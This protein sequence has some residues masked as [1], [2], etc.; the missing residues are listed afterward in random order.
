[1]VLVACE[2]ESGAFSGERVFRLRLADGTDYSGVTPAQYCLDKDKRGLA[3]DQPQRGLPIGGYV[4]AFLIDNGGEQAT[5][6]LPNGEAVQVRADQVPFRQAQE[7]E[8]HY[9]PL[10]S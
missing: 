3:R 10:G 5:V 7:R 2:I 1:M 4:V 8:A 6:E 9:V